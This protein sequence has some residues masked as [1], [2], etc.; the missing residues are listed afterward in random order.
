MLD[1]IHLARWLGQFKDQGYVFVIFPSKKYRQLHPDLKK[2]SGSNFKSSFVLI[3]HRLPKFISGYFDFISNKIILA[4][5]RSDLRI[6]QLQKVID[7]YQFDYI[8][9]CEIQ[10]AGY[11]L[12]S[13][14]S[15]SLINTKTIITNW[16]SDIYFFQEFPE[17]IKR[18]KSILSKANYYSAEC[19]RDY[20]LA[21]AY[22]FTGKFLPCIPNAGGFE[23]DMAGKNSVSTSK[24]S[25]VLIKG[26]GGLF[27]R[28]DLAISLIPEISNRFPNITFHVYS[29]TQDTIAKI[30]EH[31]LEIQ[32][33]IR[34][35]TVDKKLSHEEMLKEFLRSRVYIGCSISDGISTSF[36]EALICGTFPIQTDT[37]CANEWA[38]K[39]AIA[40]IVP[41]DSSRV[42]NAVVEALENN[43]LVDHSSMKNQEIAMKYLSKEVISKAALN[44]YV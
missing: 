24:R 39:G 12:D 11:L 17:H 33:K 22:G 34:I 30:K 19:E 18:I 27:G 16:G 26:Y 41:L 3:N 14:N 37:S 9:A 8:H 1:S 25:Q 35:T 28:S 21:S 7:K 40:S 5:F 42:M 29:A 2:L 13:V 15:D 6:K 10:G 36:I 23:V 43:Q 38:D 20:K 4:M 32:Q 44:F 31:P